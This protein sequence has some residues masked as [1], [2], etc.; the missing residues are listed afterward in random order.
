MTDCWYCHETLLTTMEVLG[1]KFLHCPTC[2]ATTVEKLPHR[3]M[4]K[5]PQVTTEHIRWMKEL[6]L[7]RT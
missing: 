5:L 2:E 1:Q 6:E 4:P 7:R 3:E